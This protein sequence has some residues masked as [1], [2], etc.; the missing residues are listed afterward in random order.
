MAIMTLVKYPDPR[1]CQVSRQVREPGAYGDLLAEM[2]VT[3]YAANGAGLAAIQVGEP[4]R[5]FII[6]AHFAGRGQ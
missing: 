2:A 1:L 4:R 6:N 3:M 5:L